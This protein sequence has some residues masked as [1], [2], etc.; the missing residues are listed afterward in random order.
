MGKASSRHCCCQASLSAVSADE[1]MSEARAMR[2][3]NKW[4]EMRSHAQMA[5]LTRNSPEVVHEAYLFLAEA[6]FHMSRFAAAKEHLA[7]YLSEKPTCPNGLQLKADLEG[8]EVEGDEASTDDKEQHLPMSHE[9]AEAAAQEIMNMPPVLE[10]A[11]ERAEAVGSVEAPL[12]GGQRSCMISVSVPISST[13]KA[14][15]EKHEVSREADAVTFHFNNGKVMQAALKSVEAV[16]PAGTVAKVVSQRTSRV[17]EHLRKEL[18][19][20]KKA[21][22]RLIKDMIS[23]LDLDSSFK[24]HQQALECLQEATEVFLSELFS[25][26]VLVAQHAKRKTVFVADMTLVLHLQ[27]RV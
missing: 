19:I 9:A 3:E 27:A 14:L 23:D 4:I 20:P 8:H 2:L 6:D 16:Q 13:L 7:W 15:L 12:H 22:A 5:L 1:H 10:A 26:C 25:R 11:T 21:F 18:Q 17:P 24:F